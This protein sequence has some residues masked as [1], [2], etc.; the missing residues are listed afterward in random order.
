MDDRIGFSHI[1][2]FT[3]C[4]VGVAR[5]GVERRRTNSEIKINHFFMKNYRK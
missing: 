1:V 5:A 2:Q 4:A 3:D